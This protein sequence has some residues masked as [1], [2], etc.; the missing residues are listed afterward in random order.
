MPV[1][2][3]V[4]EKESLK[5]SGIE[6]NLIPEAKETKEPE[7]SQTQ[8]NMENPM[9]GQEPL[10][11]GSTVVYMFER[12]MKRVSNGHYKKSLSEILYVLAIVLTLVSFGGIVIWGSNGLQYYV[13]NYKS[14]TLLTFLFPIVIYVFTKLSL[15]M[16]WF[17]YWTLVTT[18]VF[19]VLDSTSKLSKQDLS[20]ASA[21]ILVGFVILEVLTVLVYIWIRK[22]QPRV[23]RKL[24]EKDPT[25]FWKIIQDPN[26]AGHFKCRSYFGFGRVQ[27]FSY[28]GQVNERNEPHGFGKFTSEW[29][30]GEV[31]TGL[32]KNGMPIGPFKSR[33]YATGYSFQRVRIGFCTSDAAKFAKSSVKRSGTL[34][35]GVAGV[36]S[37]ATG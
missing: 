20:V 27:K 15:L 33:E 14:L 24:S 25:K 23:I 22:I 26:K 30:T 10:N 4:E 16:R 37:S 11:I 32:W 5:M 31:L 13:E 2:A 1:I 3:L 28:V 17:L 6:S 21:W 8:I 7:H 36:E 18:F 35:F 34:R 29:K 9:P 19:F 12:E